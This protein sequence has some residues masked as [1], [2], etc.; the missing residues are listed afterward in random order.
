VPQHSPTGDGRIPDPLIPFT[1]PYS[2]TL[3]GAPF[4][5]TANLNQPVWLDVFIPTNTVSGTYTGSVTVTANSQ[6]A[7]VVPWT[8]GAGWRFVAVYRGRQA[9]D[10][11]YQL[12][13]STGLSILGGIGLTVVA[14]VI[15][16][17]AEI[18][19]Y[20]MMSVFTM[21]LAAAIGTAWF[22]LAPL[23]S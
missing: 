7:V 21:L 12:L 16:F 13:R 15:L 23:R 9:N 14:I 8:I 10:D 1:D 22:L 11:S 20:L 3:V 2:R 6:P 18:A 17:E 5:V 4:T 19:L